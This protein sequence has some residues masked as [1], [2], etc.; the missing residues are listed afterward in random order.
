MR[1]RVS[2]RECQRERE[3]KREI[4]ERE[5]MRDLTSKRM[6]NLCVVIK[7]L[8]YIECVSKMHLYEGHLTQIKCQRILLPIE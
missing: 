2:V 4:G 3:R 6:I 1:E 8:L 5:R 7:I